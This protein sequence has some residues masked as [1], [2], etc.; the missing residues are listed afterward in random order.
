MFLRKGVAFF[1]KQMMK[2]VG[3][4]VLIVFLCSTHLSI[5]QNTTRQNENVESLRHAI[6]V[7][8]GTAYTARDKYYY[9]PQND[10]D[11]SNTVDLMLSEFTKTLTSQIS[12]DSTIA[13]KVV[14]VDKDKGTM[15]I[16]VHQ[17][18]AYTNQKTGTTMARCTMILEKTEPTK[19]PVLP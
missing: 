13:V 12:S 9:N 17:K 1:V 3:Y 5:I 8:M 14:N 19:G 16:E 7:A 15:D 6:T 11:V 2:T 18:Y 10:Q 4:I